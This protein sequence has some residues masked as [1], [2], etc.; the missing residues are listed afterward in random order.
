MRVL[1]DGNV[2]LIQTAGGV[3]RYFANLISRLPTNI[4]PHLTTSQ[5]GE[6]N[7]PAHPN[8]RTHKFNRFRPAGLSYRVEKRYFDYV[9]ATNR[10]DIAH[11]TYYTLL[12]RREVKDYR[13]PIVIT[14]WDMIHELFPAELD[15]TG[16]QADEK[17][18]AVMAADAVIC[19]SENTRNDLLEHYSLPEN[20]VKVTHLASDLNASLS[21]GPEPVPSRPYFLYVG[22]RYGYKNFDGLLKAFAKARSARP[23]IAV[24]VVGAPFNEAEQKLLRDLKVADAIDH[25]GAVGDAHLAK[26]YRR[27]VAFVYPSLYEGFGIP[28]LEA[29]SCGTAVIAS[30][31]SSIP[32]VVGDGGMLF[33][34]TSVNALADLLLLMTDDESARAR[35]IAKGHERAKA[36][37]WDQTAAQTVEIYR[38]LGAANATV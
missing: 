38:S 10:F 2:Y 33:D 18:R 13:C 35:L 24:C 17:R 21:H 3:N 12:T 4:I 5:S 11:P 31:S 34:P 36:F 37:S 23:E 29:M 19:I 25:Y 9:T 14:V 16:R 8:L 7:Y 6:V 27:S 32:E 28:P 30:N 20:K 1:Y 26:L 22:R 15:P